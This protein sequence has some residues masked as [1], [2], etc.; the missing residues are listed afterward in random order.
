MIDVLVVVVSISK[1]FCMDSS[2]S[3]ILHGPI[4]TTSSSLITDKIECSTYYC[5][6]LMSCD[7]Y[8]SCVVGKRLELW[9]T[10]VS[11]IKLCIQEDDVSLVIEYA[12]VYKSWPISHGHFY[13]INIKTSAR[14]C[15]NPLHDQNPF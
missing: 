2:S 15:N 6:Y 11:V 7:I 9:V 13:R 5:E 12:W 1:L 3:T 8:R 10:S 4:F 14:G